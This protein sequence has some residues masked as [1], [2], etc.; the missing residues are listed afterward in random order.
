MSILWEESSRSCPSMN[1]PIQQGLKL[2]EQSLE[3]LFIQ[4]CIVERNFIQAT[5]SIGKASVAKTKNWGFQVT[6]GLHKYSRVQ[7]QSFIGFHNPI[8]SS[9]R[10]QVFEGIIEGR[11]NLFCHLIVKQDEL[12]RCLERLLHQN[13][14]IRKSAL[15]NFPY[16]SKIMI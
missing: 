6:R 4:T 5:S 9:S 3:K 7:D 1:N 2:R 16:Q 12:I 14:L 11:H 10:F 13:Y 8:Y 15:L